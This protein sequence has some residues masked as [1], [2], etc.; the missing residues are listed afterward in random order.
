MLFCESGVAQAQSN[1]REQQFGDDGLAAHRRRPEELVRCRTKTARLKQTPLGEKYQRLVQVNQRG[2][3]LVLIANEHFFCLRKQL[4]GLEGLSLTAGCDGGE[5]QRFRGL[6]AKAKIVETCIGRASQFAG[7]GAQIQLQVDFREVKI[8]Q[9][10]LIRVVRFFCADGCVAEHLN[11]TPI[12]SAQEMQIGDVVVG[13]RHQNRHVFLLTVAAR[14]LMQ[15]Q[16]FGE[17]VQTDVAKRQVTQNR[18]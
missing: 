11:R 2:P 15:F 10:Q 12:L 6:V 7:L 16:C 9:R 18:S 4:D 17:I 1:S 8:A 5:A 13:I 14:D 3:D